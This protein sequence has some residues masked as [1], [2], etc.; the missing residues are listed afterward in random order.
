MKIY[1]NI[2]QLIGNTPLIRIKRI[3]KEFNSLAEI[4]VKVESFNPLNSVK[5][6]I[7]YAMIND[8]LK[9]GVINKDTT[10]VEPTSGNTGIGL[11]YVS[12]ALGLK[13]IVTMPE[14]MSK[15]RILIMQALGAKVIL[16]EGS[17]GMTGAINKAKEIVGNND[18]HYM[19]QQFNNPSN[20]EIHRKTTALEILKDTDGQVD[21]FVAG[22]GTG[23]TIT[24]VGEVLKNYNSNIKVIAVEPDSSAVLS[25]EKPGP[26][27]IQGIGA[28]FIP[29]VLNTNIYDEIIKVSNEDAINM[30]K[31]IAK[32]EGI[33]VGVSSG[34]ALHAAIEVSK[35]KENANKRIV[36]ILP[37]TGERYLT[38]SVFENV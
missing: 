9:S 3:E 23:G 19:L 7:A 36:V 28:G 32:K 26:H 12:A 22:V 24:G 29:N 1:D 37:D 20:P 33:F 38:T 27:K 14:T 17:L 13:L 15:E 34:A 30:T 2:T 10:L 11:A 8:A 5:D 18:N 4:V 31:M 35:R 21:I 25:N 6:R 16:T